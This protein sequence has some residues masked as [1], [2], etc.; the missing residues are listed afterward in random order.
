MNRG[1]CQ[2]RHRRR[3]PGIGV[4]FLDELPE[5]RRDALEALRPPLED[6]LVTLARATA[7]FAYPPRFTL[8]AAM[9]PCLCGH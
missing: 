5:F 7:T 8:V 4:L 6:G 1:R 2:R 9:N 3:D